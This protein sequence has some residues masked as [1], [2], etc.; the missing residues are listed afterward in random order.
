MEQKGGIVIQE[1]LAR[2]LGLSASRISSILDS[3]DASLPVTEERQGGGA[4]HRGWI[5]RK[6][7]PVRRRQKAVSLTGHGE[8]ILRT[9]RRDYMHQI[10]K[11]VEAVGLRDLLQLRNL[12]IRLNRALNSNHESMD[13]DYEG[14]RSGRDP[15]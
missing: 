10:Y 1:N 15:F 12:L 2:E 11:A 7:N 14:E 8:T 5:V 6:D 3:M 13:I 4:N 9:A